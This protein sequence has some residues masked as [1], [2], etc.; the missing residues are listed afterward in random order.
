MRAAGYLLKPIRLERLVDALDAAQQRNRAQ[1]LAAIGDSMQREDHREVDFFISQS[2]RKITRIPLAQVIYF[3]AD[4]KY[5]AL[6]H[7]DGAELIDES[8]KQIELHYPQ[9]FLRIHRSSLIAPAFAKGLIRRG[10]GVF[11]QF[12]G[13]PDALEISRR[14]LSQVKAL[15]RLE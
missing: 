11:L 4:Q 5:T 6:R 1:Q 10:D 12:H 2:L 7:G 9:Q 3:N 13:I 8:L 14:H 15:L